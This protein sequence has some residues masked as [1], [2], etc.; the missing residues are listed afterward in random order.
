M[1]YIHAVKLSS[2]K[3]SQMSK[4]N[5]ISNGATIKIKKNLTWLSA[6]FPDVDSTCFINQRLKFLLDAL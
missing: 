6:T 1:E 5:Y 4:I 2:F 3:R